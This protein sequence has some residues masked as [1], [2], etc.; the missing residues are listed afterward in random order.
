MN[1]TPHQMQTQNRWQYSLPAGLCLC[2][3][4]VPR[5]ITVY[6]KRMRAVSRSRPM[7]T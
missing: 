1:R 3:G 5:V 4:D 6:S 2:A 7:N